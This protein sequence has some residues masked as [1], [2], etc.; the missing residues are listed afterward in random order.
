[1][2]GTADVAMSRPA[3]G[4]DDRAGLV[5]VE[6][7]VVG[8]DDDLAAGETAFLL[9]HVLRPR[10]RGVDRTLKQTGRE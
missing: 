8:V 3:A 7:R 1:L 6:V 2:F 5:G 9:V 10:L 4:F